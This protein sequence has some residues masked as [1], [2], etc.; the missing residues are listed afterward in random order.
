MDLSLIQVFAV[1]VVVPA[2]DVELQVSS[3]VSIPVP[4]R[5]RQ[6]SRTSGSHGMAN[7]QAET[8]EAI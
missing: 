7:H 8:L 1:H 4:R 6:I 5:Q 3:S 2:T